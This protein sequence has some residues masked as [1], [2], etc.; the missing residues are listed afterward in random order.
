MAS[1]DPLVVVDSGAVCALGND[2][3]QI[4]VAWK[5]GCRRFL[6]VPR[7]PMRRD[8]RLPPL[9]RYP[10]L[11]ENLD[12]WQ[13]MAEL[14]RLA[15]AQAIGPMQARMETPLWES[16]RVA[17]LLSL[18][19]PRPGLAPWMIERAAEQIAGCVPNVQAPLCATVQ[20]GHD[21]FI[22]LLPT[23]RKLLEAGEVDLCLVGGVDS[24]IDL[25]YL[26]WLDACDRLKSRQHP[27]GSMP[28]EGAAFCAL[29]LRSRIGPGEA[30]AGA[31]RLRQRERGQSLVPRQA[32]PGPGPDPSHRPLRGT[33]R[34]GG[35]VL[36]R[37]QWRGVA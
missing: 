29:A 5:A 30:A 19:P 33:D 8:G 4:H 22:G 35:R 27:F 24:A 28:G 16:V 11:D 6:Q 18:P 2:P 21:G 10:V 14:G 31:S 26:D 3:V 37:P 15:A 1:P 25:E 20:Q 36:R 12:P 32:Q 13:R 7:L 17:L 23:A 9:A 34:S